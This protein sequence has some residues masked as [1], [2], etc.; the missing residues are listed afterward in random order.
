MIH[1]R[2]DVGKALAGTGAGSQH[3][4]ATFLRFANCVFLVLVKQQ[5]FTAADCRRFIAPENL[6]A[7]GGEHIFLCQFRD[8]LAQRR[9]RS[10]A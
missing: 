5:V 3:V 8:G 9:F 10:V 4:V 6:G 1:D 7:A 2:H